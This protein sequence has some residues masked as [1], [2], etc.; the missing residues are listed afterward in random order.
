MTPT[1]TLLALDPGVT[2]GV[3]IRS[4]DN[5]IITRIV[6][7]PRDLWGIIQTVHP[8]VVIF[9]DFTT[10]GLISKDGLYTVRLIGGIEAVTNLCKVPIHVQYPAER[11]P[12]IASAKQILKASGKKYLVHEID[13]LSH[14]LLY[15]HLRAKNLL[16][17]NRRT[18]NVQ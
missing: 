3:A 4:R 7:R 15:E 16:P 17:T 10:P 18:N 9:E 12:F 13:A 1:L 8:D 11:Y 5:N 14:L 2:T 6:H